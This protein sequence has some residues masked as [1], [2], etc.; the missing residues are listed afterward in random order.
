M[1]VRQ[2]VKGRDQDPAEVRKWTE[3]LERTH[4]LHEAALTRI[5]ELV[6][7]VDT[8]THQRDD[9]LAAA[10]RMVSGAWMHECPAGVGRDCQAV[11]EEDF[12]AMRVA[13]E[14]LDAEQKKVRV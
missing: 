6:L 14:N 5:Q 13:C 4:A 7:K 2:T 3:E 10:Q 12:S 11:D 1:T 8:L 9:L